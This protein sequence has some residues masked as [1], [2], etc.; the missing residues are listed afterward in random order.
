M[1]PRV[2]SFV[3]RLW[4]EEGHFRGRRCVEHREGRGLGLVDPDA[5]AL[6]LRAFLT[7][8]VPSCE[9]DLGMLWAWPNFVLRNDASAGVV[10]CSH[11]L[12]LGWG[13]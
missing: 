9:H 11:G 3:S 2:I 12:L 10:G 4:L 5:S 6:D 8:R 1:S 13:E 7:L